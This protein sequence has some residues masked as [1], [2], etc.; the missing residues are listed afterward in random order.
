MNGAFALVRPLPDLAPFPERLADLAVEALLDEARLTPKPG[1]VD[2]R[3]AGA[4]HDLSLA[5]MCRSAYALRPAFIAMAA[6]AHDQPVSIA[7]REQLGAIGRQA[8]TAMMQTTHG[9]N[10]HRGAIW[11]MGLLVAATAMAQHDREPLA[12]VARA[13]ALARIEDR[14]Q[15]RQESNGSRVCQHYGVPGAR[16]EAQANFPHVIGLGLPTLRCF[17]NAGG[18][19]MTARVNAL[20]AI[21]SRL[22]DTCVLSRGGKDALRAAQNGALAVLDAGGI[23]T[24]SG[25]RALRNLETHLLAHNASPGG[26]ADLLAAML[27]LDQIDQ[28]LII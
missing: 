28:Q 12:V 14:H 9:I 27:F 11:A 5:L 24:L 22:P 19:E 17:R 2:G 26:A 23:G 7:L 21:M 1:L 10:T 3:G 4:H 25:R 20:L 8:E 16:G 6:C 13:G 18:H 15:P